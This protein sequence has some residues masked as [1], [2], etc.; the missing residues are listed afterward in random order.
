MAA[1]KTLARRASKTAFY[2][3][4]SIAIGRIFGPVESWL[5]IDFVHSAG[6]VIYGPGDMG[7]DNFWDLLFYID[8]LTTMSITTIVYFVTMKLTNKIRNK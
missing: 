1:F 4:L 5:N 2:I 6:E 3:A 7:A 8:F